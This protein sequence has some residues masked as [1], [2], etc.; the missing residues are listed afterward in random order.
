MNFK[1][2]LLTCDIDQK[3][4]IHFESLEN[5]F[6]LRGTKDGILK[7]GSTFDSISQRT[8]KEIKSEDGVIKVSLN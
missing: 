5:P 2:L 7:S 6:Y 1:N 3:V 8:V 4:S